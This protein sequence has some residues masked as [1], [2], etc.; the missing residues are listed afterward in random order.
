MLD[1]SGTIL[2]VI[3]IQ[4]KLAR[5][6]YQADALI[7]SASKMVA[8]AK[9]LN[10]PIL[11][12]EQ[13]PNGLGPTVPEIAALLSNYKPVSKL[14]FSCCGAPEFMQQLEAIRRSQVLICGIE[15]HVCVYQTAADLI[16]L[17]YQ[18]QVL[19]DAVSSRTPENKAIGLDRCK[20]IGASIS[21]VEMAL[22]ELL[23]IAEGEEFKQMLKILK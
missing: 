13:N 8:G 20:A 14:S 4:E 16:Q 9:I 18:V 7:Q 12:T 1:S 19:A 11:W 22:F 21:S 15:C 6:M 2:V 5:S 23:K 3:D 10:L 17:G